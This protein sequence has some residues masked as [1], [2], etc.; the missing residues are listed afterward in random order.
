MSIPLYFKG[1]TGF[2]ILSLFCLLVINITLVL[3]VLKTR[4]S[5]GTKY[6]ANSVHV[7]N[8][9]LVEV[10]QTESHRTLYHR[11]IIQQQHNFEVLMASHL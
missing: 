3:S 11:H 5:V 6:E 10:R 9:F 8:L 7:A 1:R 4:P 2:C